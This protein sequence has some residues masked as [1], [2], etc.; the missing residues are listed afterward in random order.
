MRTMTRA[1]LSFL[2]AG[3]M[4]W[5]ALPAH[6]KGVSMVKAGNCSGRTLSKMQLSRENGRIEVEFEVDSNINGQRWT[7]ALRHDGRRIFKGTRTTVGRSGSFTVRRL[8]AN[9]AGGDA[10]HA[11]ARR[12]SGET[13]KVR[14]VW[15]R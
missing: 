4:A 9:R 5:G 8:E 10:F 7:V 12:R 1:M 15:R 14:A 13:C 3:S 6:A 11:V 2:I